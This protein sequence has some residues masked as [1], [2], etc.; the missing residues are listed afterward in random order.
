MVKKRK[1]SE[2]RKNNEI[3]PKEI[4]DIYIEE[5][6]TNLDRNNVKIFNLTFNYNIKTNEIR[7]IK[8]EDYKIYLRRKKL[9]RLNDKKDR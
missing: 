2:I 9:K 1:K 3:K 7:D 5:K 8:Y 4:K 6:L